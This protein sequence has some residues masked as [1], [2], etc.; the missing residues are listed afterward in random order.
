[1]TIYKHYSDFKGEWLWPNFSI[2]K[3]SCS[4]CGEYYHDIY[5]L[6]LLQGARDIAKKA[7][8]INSGHRCKK[9]NAA[10]GGRI[11]SQH[12]KI[13][14]DI[15]LRGFEKKEL[16]SILFKAGFTTFGMYNSFVHTDGRSYKKWYGCA[17]KIWGDIYNTV[18]RGDL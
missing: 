4:C 1:M 10:E 12:L 2:E 7:M 16:L 15:S 17:P 11:K 14:F 5:C 8:Y 6:D 3:L 9:H 18:I 13:A